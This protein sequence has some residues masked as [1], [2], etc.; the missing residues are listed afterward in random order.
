MKPDNSDYLRRWRL[1]QAA[2]RSKR[3]KAVLDRSRRAG[4]TISFTGVARE[5]GV[6]RSWLYE[7]PFAD[8][9]RS[10]RADPPVHRQRSEPASAASLRARLTAALEDN[11]R[12]RAE[13]QDL[14]RQLSLALGENRADSRRH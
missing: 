7:S 3:V 10:Q 14:R 2:E 9:I 8:D 6:S 5:A 11:Q 12:L 1:E 4:E 13:L